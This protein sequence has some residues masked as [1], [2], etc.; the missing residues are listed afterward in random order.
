MD[1]YTIMLVVDE[2]SP[3][4]RLHIAKYIVRRAAIGA[5]VAVAL[6]A[7]ASW[8]YTRLRADNAELDELRV[9]VAEQR[10]QIQ[11]FEQTLSDVDAELARVSELERKV[12]IIANLPGAAGIGGGGVTALAPPVP[13]GV[14]GEGDAL[15]AMPPAG[16]PVHRGPYSMLPA[17]A[18]RDP[19][20]AT[21]TGM[22]GGEAP[23]DEILERDGLTTRA[24]RHVANLERAAK[25]LGD[26]AGTQG[27]SLEELVDE[28]EDK[29]NKL[30]SMPSV[31]PTRG[32][33]TS[34][35]GPRISPFTGRRH[36]H[37]G[38]DIAA[39]NGTPITAPARGRVVSISTRG[40]LGNSVTIDHG[41]GVKTFYGHND[42]IFVNVGSEVD[43]GQKIASVGSTGRSTGPHLHYSVQING[44]A[45]DPLNYIFD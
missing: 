22:G 10:E 27:V 21:R 33:L 6:L 4:R 43:R 16:V 13:V 32:W 30:V 37:A 17:A 5:A 25:G 34:R 7:L 42:E 24:A 45:R 36:R 44:K 15:D 40:P 12:R 18:P 3:V 14:E 28:L 8:D 2:R 20:E 35:F 1:Q 19:F 26:R 9:E 31:W 29:R 38:I 11:G 39:R 41:F 23:T